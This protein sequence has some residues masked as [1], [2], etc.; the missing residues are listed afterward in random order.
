MARPMKIVPELVSVT[1]RYRIEGGPEWDAYEV[2][3]PTGVFMH[4]GMEGRTD[5]QLA[6]CEPRPASKM[7]GIHHRIFELAEEVAKSAGL[8]DPFEA[9]L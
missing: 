8:L 5:G 1:V 7:H 6:Q 2:E 9:D 3:G 4:G